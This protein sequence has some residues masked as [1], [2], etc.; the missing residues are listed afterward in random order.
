MY[1]ACANFGLFPLSVL[2]APQEGR[3]KN[4]LMALN[5]LASMDGTVNEPICINVFILCV[6]SAS[7]RLNGVQLFFFFFLFFSA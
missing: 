4:L 2:S 3:V 7:T 6:C 1:V 5:S